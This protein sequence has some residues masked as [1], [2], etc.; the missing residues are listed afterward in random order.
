MFNGVGVVGVRRC[1][2]GASFLLAYFS[3]F[4]E[5]GLNGLGLLGLG[6]AE[7]GLHFCL[8]S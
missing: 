1:G 8:S 6:V 7:L 4:A 3:I 2:T 5:L